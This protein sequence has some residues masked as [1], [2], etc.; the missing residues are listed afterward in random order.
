MRDAG[1]LRHV[2]FVALTD[3][4]FNL[5]WLGYTFA[6]C[7]FVAQRNIQGKWRKTYYPLALR[8]CPRE[9]KARYREQSRFLRR[10]LE[11]HKLPGIGQLGCDY[12]G[13]IPD[14]F[15]KDHKGIHIASSI[16]HLDKNL[17]KNQR[18]RGGV[19]I[20]GKR[21]IG[22]VR[23]YV[24]ASAVLPKKLMF[25]VWWKVTL[26]SISHRWGEQ[27]WAD[28]FRRTYLRPEAS[29]VRDETELLLSNWYYGSQSSLGKGY[30][31]WQLPLEQNNGR[32]KSAIRGVEGEDMC[33]VVRKIREVAAA[34]SAPPEDRERSF[35]RL[36][37][38]DRISF[39]RPTRPD[40]WMELTGMSVK[41]A[42]H[43]PKV[44]KRYPSIASIV[45]AWGI[46]QDSAAPT[47]RK[48][49]GKRKNGAA[50]C[51]WFMRIGV[52]GPVPQEVATRMEEQMKSK[53]EAQLVRMWLE[54]GIL[55]H[56]TARRSAEACPHKQEFQA[57]KQLWGQ[58]CIAAVDMVTK[59][60]F[61]TCPLACDRGH[62]PHEFGAVQCAG[63][64]VYVGER[65][66]PA[67]EA[68]EAESDSDGGSSAQ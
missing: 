37:S 51:W 46:T 35:S 12:F 44:S 41:A 29:S 60:A 26:S 11:A 32:L 63:L 27:D 10:E 53:T 30:G 39:G 25:S 23:Q 47:M 15:S 34:W 18:K 19:K 66:P 43:F 42:L 16:W 64:C 54:C 17:K 22:P 52:P 33:G 58:Y 31:P 21:G 68:A 61:C 56:N 8:C 13:G 36:A 2:T 9:R 57:L 28:Y 14:S 1:K 3:C 49:P 48:L 45:T 62:C 4:T 20:K 7:G 38:P 59:R 65:M 50:M 5:E 40:A 6:N 67:K 55:S 24:K